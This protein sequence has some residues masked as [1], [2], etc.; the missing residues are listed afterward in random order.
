MIED[1]SQ[2]TANPMRESCEG[3]RQEAKDVAR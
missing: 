3:C 2:P 1:L